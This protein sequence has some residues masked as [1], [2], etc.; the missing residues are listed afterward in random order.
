MSLIYDG[1]KANAPTFDIAPIQQVL[2]DLRRQGAQRIVLGCTELPVAFTRYGI[3]ATDTV[4]ATD[5]LAR[6]AV[7]AAGYPVK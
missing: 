1:I 3:D 2:A 6:V 5:I 7:A 4:D